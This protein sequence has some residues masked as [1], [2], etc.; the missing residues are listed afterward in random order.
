MFVSDES[1]ISNINIANHLEQ[2]QAVLNMLHSLQE[3]STYQQ[4]DI[5][6]TNNFAAK[7]EFLQQVHH[8]LTHLGLN[9]EQLILEGQVNNHQQTLKQTLLQMIQQQLPIEQERIQQLVHFINGLQL[10]SV[11]ETNHFIYGNLVLP[12]EKLQLNSD[13]YMQFQSKKTD[14]GQVDVNH[15]RILFFLQLEALDHTI[16]DMNVQDRIV[17][18]TVFNDHQFLKSLVKPLENSLKRRLNKMDYQLSS[19]VYKPLEDETQIVPTKTAQQFTKKSYSGVDF[20]I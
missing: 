13:L 18:I 4:L 8:S 7:S 20:R 3:A 17:S 16:V 11:E 5:V 1:M 6:H 9:Y 15:C 19:V 10:Q 2:L 12:G 14:E